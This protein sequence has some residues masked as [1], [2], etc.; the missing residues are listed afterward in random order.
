[1]LKMAARNFFPRCITFFGT[2]E[3]PFHEDSH[4][5]WLDLYLEV[6]G[7]EFIIVYCYSLMQRFQIISHFALQ[8]ILRNIREK[9]IF[10]VHVLF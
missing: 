3:T 8:R 4:L 6:D 1:M 10:T 5:N 9:C 7:I 2:L